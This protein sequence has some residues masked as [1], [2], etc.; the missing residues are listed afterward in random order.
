M[1]IPAGYCAGSLAPIWE[2]IRRDLLPTMARDYVSE[3][4]RLIAAGKQGEAR[5]LAAAF[6]S[7]VVK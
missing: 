3:M 6:Q 7:K 1:P 2:W 4:Q 5:Q